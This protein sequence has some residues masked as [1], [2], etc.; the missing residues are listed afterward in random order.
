[1][2]G[3]KWHKLG[4]IFDISSDWGSKV[5]YTHCHKPTPFMLNSNTIRIYYGF[6]DSDNKTRI[7]FVD[8]SSVDFTLQYVHHSCILDLGNIGTFDDVGVQVTSVVRASPSIVYMY[9]I[10]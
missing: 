2:L 7:S 9:Y 1:M 5:G 8:I 3:R 4:C 6:R 10:G